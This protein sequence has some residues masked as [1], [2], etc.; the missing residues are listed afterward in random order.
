MVQLAGVIISHN[1]KKTNPT[2]GVK[3]NMSGYLRTD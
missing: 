1:D 3:K 2:R